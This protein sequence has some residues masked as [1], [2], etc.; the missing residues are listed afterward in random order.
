MCLFLSVYWVCLDFPRLI[1]VTSIGAASTGPKALTTIGF[2]RPRPPRKTISWI[3]W[4]IIGA[5]LFP[6]IAFGGAGAS[7]GISLAIGLPR[8]RPLPRPRSSS[9]L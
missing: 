3:I 4:A 1:W 9:P 8:P 2:Q 6:L 7:V 5:A